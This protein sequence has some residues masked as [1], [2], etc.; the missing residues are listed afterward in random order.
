VIGIQPLA[1][2]LRSFNFRP[3]TV[4]RHP[5][6]L[7]NMHRIAFLA[8]ILVAAALSAAVDIE[9]RDN[10]RY[11]PPGNNLKVA[12]NP[13]HGH[14]LPRGEVGS[15]AGSSGGHSLPEI[16]KHRRAALGSAVDVEPR[17]NIRYDPP[18]NNL[19]VAANPLHD[20][21]LPRGYVGRRA[22]SGT[23][24]GGSSGGGSLPNGGKDRRGHLRGRQTRPNYGA[25][26]RYGPTP[27]SLP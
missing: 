24:L 2:L 21:N 23:S 15:S 10:I 16:G 20:H 22:S 12:A 11:D 5:N 27:G 4:Y 3:F 25:S 9:P 18:G 1:H 13:L 19:K 6:I 8:C 26:T 14:N 17:S 7:T